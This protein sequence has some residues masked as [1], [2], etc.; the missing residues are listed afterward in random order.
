MELCNIFSYSRFLFK[1]FFATVFG[2]VYNAK[3][4]VNLQSL[5]ALIVVTLTKNYN[6]IERVYFICRLFLLF[7]ST[8]SFLLSL[9]TVSWRYKRD[10]LHPIMETS[11]YIRY[12]PDP[13]PPTTTQSTI[14]SYAPGL[15]VRLI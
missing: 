12:D 6:I 9:Y 14:C 10:Y 3:E 7:I 15:I 11:F 8:F 2:R 5:L 1:H 13:P 4:M